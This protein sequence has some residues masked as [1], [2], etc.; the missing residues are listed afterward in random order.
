MI[1]CPICQMINEDQTRF[2]AEC[3]ARLGPAPAPSPQAP[4]APAQF[5]SQA[6]AYPPAPPQAPV[7]PQSAQPSPQSRLNSPMLAG[8]GEAP[9]VFAGQAPTNRDPA[10]IERLRK[11]AGRPEVPQT[12][13]V[14]RNPYD[15]RND[16]RMQAQNQPQDQQQAPLPQA[17]PVKKLRSPLLAGDDEFE[18]DEP[19]VQQRRAPA[20]GQH[21]HSPLLGDAGAHGQQHEAPQPSGRQHL[22]SPLLGDAGAHGQHLDPAAMTPAGTSGRHGLHSPLLGDPDDYD[23]APPQQ[24]GGSQRHLHS[25]LLGD[26]GSHG[27]HQE[28]GQPSRP[29]LHSPLL[30]SAEDEYYEDE[31]PVQRKGGLHSPML[32]GGGGSGLRSPML[33]NAAQGSGFDPYYEEYDEDPYAD[34][35][36]PNILRSPLLSGDDDFD[37]DEPPR[38][39]KKS[40]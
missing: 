14:P 8:S 4:Q 15:P 29:H 9:Q 6:P 32:G 25:P 11:M 24:A 40:L 23:D 3:G 2:C 17:K 39:S 33:S 37:E 16:P 35:G 21:L 26:A 1:Q 27:Q 18:D 31:A 19:P 28:H 20:A 36:N 38:S 5:Q 13:G 10:E 7:Q 22:H 30:G 34:E 12:D